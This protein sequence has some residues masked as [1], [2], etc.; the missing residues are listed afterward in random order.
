[1]IALCSL[2][3]TLVLSPGHAPPLLRATTSLPTNSKPHRAL[4]VSTLTALAPSG[5]DGLPLFQQSATFIG[6][7]AALGVGSV[8]TTATFEAIGNALPAGIGTN[9]VKVM[10]LLLGAAFVAAG[11]AHFALPSAYEAI[12]PPPGTWGLWVVP[13]SA[14]FHV[15][16]TG[17]CEALGGL[18][19]LLGALGDAL[20]DPLS[21]GRALALR[22][23]SAS[24]LF[25]LMV[26]VFP[27]N[28]YQYTHGAVM[29]GAG[30]DGPLPLEYH[31]VRLAVQ[32]VLLSALSLISKTPEERKV[33]V[34]A[35]PTTTDD[36]S[37]Q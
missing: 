36:A 27:A 26:A 7:M 2:C 28:I 5:I 9:F 30:P 25:V 3:A 21:G 20:N 31:Y 8:G 1:M 35:E 24:A 29:V 6:I 33:V 15:Q 22:Q 32:I 37:S 34:P 19:V 17:V 16:W 11:A 14:S 10:S 13:G 23:I 4:R 18:G 12:V